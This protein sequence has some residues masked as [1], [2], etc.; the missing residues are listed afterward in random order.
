MYQPARHL[1]LLLATIL[2]LFSGCANPTHTNQQMDFVPVGWHSVAIMPFAGDMRFAESATQS[3]AIHL[4]NVPG[5]KVIQPSTVSVSVQELG[6]TPTQNGFTVVQAKR[7]G[8]A[9]NADAIIVGTVTSYNNGATLNG[10]CTAQIIDVSTGEIV[11]ASHNPSGLLM[12]FSEHQC[13]MAATERT[14]N[15]ILRMLQDLSRKNR[16]SPRPS[17]KSKKTPEA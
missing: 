9:I 10:F 1:L 13:V 16:P 7:V 14:G 4:L 2:V 5:F 12:G 17:I 8:E 6:I 11:G 15:A 3:F